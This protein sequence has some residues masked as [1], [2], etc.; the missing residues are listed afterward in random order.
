MT[1]I[2][3]A[4]DNVIIAD[5]LENYLISEGFD[6]CGVAANV[7]EAVAM[8][9]SHKPDVGVFDFRLAGGE[10]GSQIRPLMKNPYSMGI[11]YVS[12]DPLNDRLT[13][14]D[15]EAY[16]QKP[17][18][19]KDLSRAL[20]IIQDM[21]TNKNVSESLFPKSFHLLENADGNHRKSA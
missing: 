11:L 3:I 16:I 1:K 4:E 7:S 14:A 15:G 13:S 19:M 12:G 21:K 17:Y 9:D 8:A 10:R 6:V 5:M 20:T 18:G 2:L